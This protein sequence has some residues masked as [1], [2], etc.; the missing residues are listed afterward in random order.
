MAGRRGFTDLREGKTRDRL[1]RRQTANR[2]KFVPIPRAAG[3]LGHN[4]I[5]AMSYQGRPKQVTGPIDRE[6]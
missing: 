2:K 6:K 3:P 5:A 1:F 4:L